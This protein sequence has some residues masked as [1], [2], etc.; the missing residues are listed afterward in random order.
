L[1]PQQRVELSVPDAERLGLGA[2]DEVA[3]SQ[4][5]SSVRAKVSIKERVPEGTC[6]LIEGTADGNANQLL[7]GSPVSVQIEKISA[8]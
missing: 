5:G 6:L 4:N 7:N 8:P 3:V 1:A 2:G